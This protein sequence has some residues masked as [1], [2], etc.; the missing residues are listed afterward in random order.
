MEVDSDMKAVWENLANPMIAISC[1]LLALAP[2]LSCSC[3]PEPNASSPTRTPSSTSHKPTS[4]PNPITEPEL[5]TSLLTDIPCAAPCWLNINPGQSDGSDVRAQLRDSPFI[6]K[7]TLKYEMTEE[8][9]VPVGLFYWQAKSEHYNRIILRDKIVLRME[10]WVDHDWT[11]GETVDKYG[12]PENV[13][14]VLD[15]VGE[16]PYYTVVLDYPAQGLSFASW[17]YPVLEEDFVVEEGVGILPE[18]LKVTVVYYYTPMSFEDALRDV[19]LYSPEAIEHTLEVAQEWEGFGRV[20]LA[21]TLYVR[22]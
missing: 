1:L 5:D 20:K 13:Y 7:G 19:F 6:R 11:L 22:R 18:D 15:D 3:K 10:I 12:S 21:D 14:A 17:S 4:T 9:G 8:A 2:V 16:H